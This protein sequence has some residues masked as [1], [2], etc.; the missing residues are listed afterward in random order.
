M[1]CQTDLLLLRFAGITSFS[2]YHQNYRDI[3]NL[4]FFIPVLST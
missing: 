4:S 3:Q 2:V 1:W